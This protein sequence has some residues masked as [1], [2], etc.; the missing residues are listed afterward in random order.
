MYRHHFGF[1]ERPFQ[2]VPNPAYLFLS[3]C[4]E[5]ALAHLNYAT[6]QGDGFVEITGEAGTG[7]T[8][9]CRAFIESLDARTEVAYIFN[10]KLTADELLAAVHD[11]FGLACDAC[12]TTKVRIDSLNAFLLEQKSQG[13]K[14]L[15]VIDEAQNLSQSVLEQV[16][17]LSNLETRTE[18]LLQIILVGQPE[19]GDML[20]SYE[21]RQLG[22]RITLSTHL[23]PLSFSDTIRY[24]RHRLHIAT[25][26]AGVR[27]SHAA[28]R[29][30]FRYSKG[31]PRLIHIVCD[32]ALL[33]AYVLGRQQVTG[34]I[35]RTAVHELAGRAGPKR[36]ITKRG[37]VLAVL[38]GMGCLALVAFFVLRAGH[39]SFHRPAVPMDGDASRQTPMATRA[40]M[41]AEKVA[42]SRAEA[43]EAPRGRGAGPLP[44]ASF[45]LVDRQ[46]ALM[47]ALSHWGVEAGVN[48]E[49]QGIRNDP[50]FFRLAAE[51]YDFDVYRLEGD[52][53]L[54]L[55]LNLPAI[56]AFYEPGMNALQYR[57]LSRIDGEQV[58]L[59]GARAS[60]RVTLP[61]TGVAARWSGVAYIPWKNFLGCRGTIPLGASKNSIRVLKHLLKN[62][63]YEKISPGAVYDD[64]ARAA[65]K[66]FQE[67]YGL[68]VDGL[69]GSLTKILLY[70]EQGTFDIPHIRVSGKGG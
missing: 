3:K 9:L 61:I 21:L 43:A 47:T 41:P 44:P 6:A 50:A 28:F 35:V 56:L 54:L 33:V 51:S 39:F 40:E 38:G 48:P 26:G 58:I 66:A 31:I 20:D 16:R 15:L 63:G 70:N 13:K 32:R 62:I 19:L 22:Q 12:G 57:I 60:D 11:E 24:I 55:A 68:H 53:G 45:A 2:L 17:L 29:R 30:I 4:H 14:V 46:S 69:V 67:K 65:V 37:W 10:P 49:A 42:V 59:V 8:T 34:G 5:E 52:L 23:S 27:F 7:K 18:K 25:P 1:K 36:G 64:G